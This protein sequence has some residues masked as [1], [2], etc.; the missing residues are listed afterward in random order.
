[1]SGGSCCAPLLEGVVDNHGATR[2][3]YPSALHD[4]LG[5]LDGLSDLDAMSKN[6]DARTSRRNSRGASATWSA[7]VVLRMASRLEPNGDLGG[8]ESYKSAPF[9]CDLIP[10]RYQSGAFVGSRGILAGGP[11]ASR[12]SSEPCS[13]ADDVLVVDMTASFDGDGDPSTKGPDVAG[14]SGQLD[15]DMGRVVRAL[16][17]VRLAMPP[18]LGDL[19]L[20]Q[21]LAT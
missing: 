8:V 7:S 17:D 16:G 18:P 11:Q 19:G 1:M 10:A 12:P 21:P 6:G 9:D 20:V 4:T 14:Q 2:L 5:P 13:G 3:S 15:L